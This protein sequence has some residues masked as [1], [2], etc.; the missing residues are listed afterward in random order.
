MN[1][2]KNGGYARNVLYFVDESHLPAQEE[3][4]EWF[5]RSSKVQDPFVASR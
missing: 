5:H 1:T 2:A 3:E 4:I